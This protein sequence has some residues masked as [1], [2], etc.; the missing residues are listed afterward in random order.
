MGKEN[1][2][3]Q[4]RDSVAERI[5][6]RTAKEAAEDVARKAL[7]ETLTLAEYWM[8]AG[9]NVENSGEAFMG[10]ENSANVWKNAA[11][12]K[13]TRVA[14]LEAQLAAVS[15][16]QRRH[17]VFAASEQHRRAVERMH[18]QLGPCGS[19]HLL[20]MLNAIR[21]GD[22]SPTKACRWLGWVQGALCSEGVM[23][24]DECKAI[25]KAASD[26]SSER[27]E[28]SKEK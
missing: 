7:E 12:A 18:H 5:A 14:E 4:S 22:F 11:Y 2:V 10:A 16:L 13:A 9:R 26:A 17:W 20:A 25:N 1:D 3:P 8:R 28:I 21:D 19:I 23:S 15:E 6:T 24:L 27:P